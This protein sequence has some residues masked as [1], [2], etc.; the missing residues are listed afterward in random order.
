MCIDYKTLPWLMPSLQGSK[1]YIH[2]RAY[3][4]VLINRLLKQ[5]IGMLPVKN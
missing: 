2:A 4:Q 1:V 3:F 5:R